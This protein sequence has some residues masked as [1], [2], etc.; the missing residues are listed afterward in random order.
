MGTSNTL[1][2]FWKIGALEVLDKCFCE[3]ATRTGCRTTLLQFS[4]VYINGTLKRDHIHV[5]SSIFSLCMH[6]DIYI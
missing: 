2:T 5:V 6:L 3:V 1:Q 4:M